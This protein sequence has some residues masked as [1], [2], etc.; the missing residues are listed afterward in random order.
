MSVM[1]AEPAAPKPTPVHILEGQIEHANRRE[2]AILERLEQIGEGS[3]EAQ[4]LRS[5]LAAVRA[6]RATSQRELDPHA[7]DPGQA[8]RNAIFAEGQ[9]IQAAKL[10]EV[11]RGPSA[12]EL[13]ER[14]R[15][16]AARLKQIIDVREREAVE[17]LNA[18]ADQCAAQGDHRQARILRER[19]ARSTARAV[20]SAGVAYLPTCGSQKFH[21]VGF[22]RPGPGGCC[23]TP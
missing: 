8:E 1:Y 15:N 17:I 6:L 11:M 9:R 18:Q 14:Q 3:Y 2:A 22:A 7:V 23:L 5:E 20:R 16:A 10:A 4:E 12:E 13:A 21:P 19:C